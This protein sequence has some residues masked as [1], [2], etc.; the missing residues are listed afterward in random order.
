M[1]L[2]LVDVRAKAAAAL[3]PVDDGDPAVLDITDAVDPPCIVVGW[4]EPWLQGV[5]QSPTLMARLSLICIGG[6]MDP[7]PG[8]DA[9]EQVLTYAL[10][11]LAGD[12]WPWVPQSVSAPRAFVVAGVNYLAAEAAIGIPV[13][14]A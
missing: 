14:V 2:A 10:A 4:G 9:V 5:G 1:P 11:R 6:R 8:V 12:A 7:G 3:A 13:Q